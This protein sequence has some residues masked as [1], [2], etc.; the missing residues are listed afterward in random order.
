[1]EIAARTMELELADLRL[2]DVEDE[3]DN[4]NEGSDDIDGNDAR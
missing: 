1:M 4:S 3:E 2:Q